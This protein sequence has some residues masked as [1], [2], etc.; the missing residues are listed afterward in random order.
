MPYCRKGWKK[1]NT[2]GGDL[3]RIIQASDDTSI[4]LYVPKMPAYAISR[5]DAAS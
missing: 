3:R 1:L 4:A 2:N 5:G